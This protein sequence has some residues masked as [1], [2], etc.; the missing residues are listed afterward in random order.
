MLT[1]TP[2]VSPPQKKSCCR[3]HLY[4][5]KR[6]VKYDEC[7]TRPMHAIVTR[8]D[9]MNLKSRSKSGMEYGRC[10]APGAAGLREPPM[11]IKY[12]WRSLL[13]GSARVVLQNSAAT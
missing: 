13:S 6:D 4:G 2:R 3:L 1:K 5:T 8:V 7:H 11:R 9:H 12:H 10:G